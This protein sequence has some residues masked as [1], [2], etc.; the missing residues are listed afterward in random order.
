[1]AQPTDEC[2]IDAP[3]HAGA[4]TRI[5][6]SLQ[7]QFGAGLPFKF[8]RP[9]WEEEIT[10]CDYHL[11]PPDYEQP[12]NPVPPGWA[13]PEYR[14]GVASPEGIVVRLIWDGEIVT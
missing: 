2:G 14:P 11:N 10:L 8:K 9:I 13:P 4:L 7:P 1:M 5:V 3:Y 6:V 12:P